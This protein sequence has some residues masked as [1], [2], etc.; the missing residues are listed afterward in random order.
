MGKGTGKKGRE[1]PRPR[2][3]QQAPTTL[4][5]PLPP[6]GDP[7]NGPEEPTNYRLSLISKF[8]PPRRKH[9]TRRPRDCS[10][11]ALFPSPLLQPGVPSATPSA[12]IPGAPRSE[13]DL[14]HPGERNSI[15]EAKWRHNV[16]SGP[17]G[18]ALLL[19]HP[20]PP[21]EPSTDLWNG[22]LGKSS[23]G[24]L[25][26]ARVTTARVPWP[27][28]CPLSLLHQQGGEENPRRQ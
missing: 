7:P 18:P 3:G 8:L 17:Q 6:R 9:E 21:A 15:L 20:T 5:G 19:C 1:P 14:L 12:G 2:M 25:L 26:P 27:A 22:C 11:R 28:G 4:C 24:I 23:R 10:R 16:P 13:R